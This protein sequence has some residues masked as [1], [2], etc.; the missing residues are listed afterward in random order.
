M[1]RLHLHSFGDGEPLV[2]LHGVTGHGQ[3][4]ERLAP[5]RH[6]TVD[7]GHSIMWEDVQAVA[8]AVADFLA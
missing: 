4:F 5:A 3:R 6:V 7:G 1:A 8:E 2:C